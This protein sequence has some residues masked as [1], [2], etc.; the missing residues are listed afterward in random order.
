MSEKFKTFKKKYKSLKDGQEEQI[1]N[2]TQ[3]Y[4]DQLKAKDNQLQQLSST[5]KNGPAEDV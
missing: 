1:N 3:Q 5:D 2:L 4:T